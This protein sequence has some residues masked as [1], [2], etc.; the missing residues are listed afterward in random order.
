MKSVFLDHAR[1]GSPESWVLLTD[2]MPGD[3]NGFCQTGR[4]VARIYE[5]E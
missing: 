4:I 2:S 5:T 1:F 3:S